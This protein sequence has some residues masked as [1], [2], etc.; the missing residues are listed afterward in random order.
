MAENISKTQAQNFR[1][2][3]IIFIFLLAIMVAIGFYLWQQAQTL[4]NQYDRIKVSTV[5][6]LRE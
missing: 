4:D 6:N 1:K 3:M 5:Y 2:G